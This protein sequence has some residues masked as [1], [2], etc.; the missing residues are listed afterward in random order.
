MRKISEHPLSLESEQVISL[1]ADISILTLALKGDIPTLCVRERVGET[2]REYTVCL[3]N[4]DQ[5][6]E[7]VVGDYVGTVTVSNILRH[8]FIYPKK[9]IQK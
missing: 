8:F 3:I 7:I 5:P 4:G 6:Y 9:M 1:P 2:Q